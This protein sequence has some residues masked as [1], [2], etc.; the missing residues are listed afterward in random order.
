MKHLSFPTLVG[1]LLLSYTLC[2]CQKSTNESPVADL[3]EGKKL[4]GKW[5]PVKSTVT[6]K[7]SDGTVQNVSVPAEPGDVIE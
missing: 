4:E 5:T 7:Y 1:A 2:N 3:F 6:L